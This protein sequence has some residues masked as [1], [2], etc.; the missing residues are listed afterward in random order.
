MRV[1][2]WLAL[3]AGGCSVSAKEPEAEPD[4]K[5]WTI[6]VDMSGTQRFVHPETSMSWPVAGVATATEGVA[7]IDVAGMPVMFGADGAF[8][9]EVP[10]SLG[11]TPVPVLV[12]DAAGHER[13]GD[14]TLLAA[15]F[16]PDTEHNRVAASLVLD[17]TILAAMSGGIASQAANVDIAG[18]ILA[19]EYLSQ[20]SQ[21]AT[22]SVH[23]HQGTVNVK[24]VQDR[25]DL[26]LHIQIPNVYV[27]FEGECQGPL[28]LIPLA[29]EMGG[30]IDVWSQL[31]PHAGE[32]PCLEAFHHTAP[33][34]TIAGW[35][36]NVWGT[37]GPLQ[38]WM[39]TAFSGEKATQARTQLTTEVASR[40][41]ELLTTQLANISVF[42]RTSQL[43]LL[44]R[45]IGLHLCLA[46]LDKVGNALV[47]RI[48]AQAL[49]AGVRE[50][51]GAPQIDGATPA[52]PAKELVLDG[53]LVGQLLFASW[54]DGGLT[55]AV[56][57]AD[58]SVLQILVP[59]LVD[60]FPSS[61][62]AQVTVDAELPPLVRATPGGPGDLSVEVGD[63]MIDLTV[64]GKRIF[65]FGV[66]LNMALDL[67]PVAGKLQPMVIDATAKAVLLDELYDGP[68]AALEAAVQVQISKLA[69]SLL[70]ASAAIALP[71]LPGLGSPVAVSA[72]AGGRFLHVTLGP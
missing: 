23:A 15:R 56:S 47:A 35:G 41:G 21:C 24:L 68:D 16:L 20:D 36:F 1:L 32:G 2:A 61:S 44:D 72:D 51:P 57:D 69:A 5:G 31:T 45:P 6:S 12:R 46:A 38:N 67:V 10:V 55:R 14:R 9:A 7:S 33:E 50:A 53:N 26:W 39:V 66:V 37:G 64:E 29:G 65:R 11:L 43:E 8:A 59:E 4:P 48:A 25:G 27:Y 49:G 13:K 40:A 42:D 58:I 28:R 30:T 17:N 18:E 63:V 71:E 22:W 70:G 60:R 62:T 52:V 54:R 34:V 3:V 19:R